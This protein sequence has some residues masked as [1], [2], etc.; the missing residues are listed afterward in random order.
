ML[1]TIIFLTG[2]SAIRNPNMTM[3]AIRLKDYLEPTGGCF[4]PHMQ[5]PSQ[6]PKAHSL[7]LVHTIIS[8]AHLVRAYNVGGASIGYTTA[9]PDL[10]VCEIQ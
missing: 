7:F 8:L 2:F 1:Q 6:K 5:Y 10:L 4:V 9:N 3:T